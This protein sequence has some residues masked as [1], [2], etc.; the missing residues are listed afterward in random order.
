MRVYLNSVLCVRV[1]SLEEASNRVRA[2]LEAKMIGVRDWTG[3]LAGAVFADGRELARV[4][5]NGRITFGLR[6]DKEQLE[7]MERALAYYLSDITDEPDREAEVESLH[8]QVRHTLEQ[9]R[10]R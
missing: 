5:Y 1:G 7:I 8:Q 9:A 4:S 2:Y 3:Q 10:T 6:A